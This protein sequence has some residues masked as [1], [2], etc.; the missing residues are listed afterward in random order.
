MKS[1]SRTIAAKFTPGAENARTDT[2]GDLDPHAGESDELRMVQADLDILDAA[3]TSRQ[4]RKQVR[5]HPQA[6]LL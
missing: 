1:A 2:G 3:E 4:L 6:G 5:E